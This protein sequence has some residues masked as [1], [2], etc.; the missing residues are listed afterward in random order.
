MSDQVILDWTLLRSS[1]TRALGLTHLRNQQRELLQ[2]ILELLAVGQARLD[3]GGAVG[4]ADQ[5]PHGV[6][7]HWRENTQDPS[8]P[9]TTREI[10]SSCPQR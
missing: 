8:D 4:P 9:G 1:Q 5:Q 6:V 2:P 7:G 3:G 10:D